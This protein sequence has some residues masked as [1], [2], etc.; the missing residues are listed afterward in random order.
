VKGGEE[1]QCLVVL[2]PCANGHRRRRSFTRPYMNAEVTL[3][4]GGE[5]DVLN[6]G[7]GGGGWGVGGGRLNSASMGWTSPC[8]STVPLM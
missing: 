5:V 1:W 7:V 8:T 3:V 6:G 4:L 2:V